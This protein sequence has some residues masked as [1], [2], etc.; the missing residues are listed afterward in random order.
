M[1]SA[2]EDLRKGYAEYK[3]DEV[4]EELSAEDKRLL[5]TEDIDTLSAR[6]KMRLQYLRD[7]QGVKNNGGE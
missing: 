5:E 7:K 1:S 6:A 4:Q 2:F 3:E